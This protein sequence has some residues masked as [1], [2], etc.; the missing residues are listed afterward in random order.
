[1]FKIQA[2]AITTKWNIIRYCRPYIS[3][4]DATYTQVW[5][6]NIQPIP[7]P[8]G[9][10]IHY[11]CGLVQDCTNCIA[12]ALELLQSCTKTSIYCKCFGENW[13]CYHDSTAPFVS[14]FMSNLHIPPNTWSIVHGWR[15]G[16]NPSCLHGHLQDI[17][18]GRKHRL[19]ALCPDTAIN[20][21][22]EQGATCNSLG[23]VEANPNI[24]H[25]F[26]PDDVMKW[27]Q[28]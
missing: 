28:M 22:L 13:P 21:L 16:C 27:K 10:A 18:T 1:M 24:I 17:L 15:H 9:H 5:S 2:G 4:N 19:M 26:S 14:L 7:P 6:Q 3:N 8:E 20:L 11:L 12:Q 25:F 23:A